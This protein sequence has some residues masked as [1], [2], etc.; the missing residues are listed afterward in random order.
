MITIVTLKITGHHNE[1]NNNEKTKN[2][3]RTTK[4]WHRDT[5]WTNAGGKMV[6]TDLQGC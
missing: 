2:I 1:Y 4:M 3:A 5:K 6:L